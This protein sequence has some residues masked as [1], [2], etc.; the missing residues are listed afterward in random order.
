MYCA[1]AI[2]NVQVFLDTLL[3][4]ELKDTMMPHTFLRMGFYMIAGTVLAS[5]TWSTIEHS[6][7]TGDYIL[8]VILLPMMF[9]VVG[10]FFVDRWRPEYGPGDFH[11]TRLWKTPRDTTRSGLWLRVGFKT[12]VDGQHL[13]ANKIVFSQVNPDAFTGIIPFVPDSRDR[14]R[15]LF[16]FHPPE[17]GDIVIFLHPRDTSRVVVKRVIGLPGDMIEMEVGRVIRNGERL[18]EP[19]VVPRD[20]RTL[21]PVVAPAG[22][23]YVL[24]DNRLVSSDS[25]DWGFVPEELII[26][27]AWVRYWPSER[28][29]VLDGLR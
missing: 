6:A 14:G 20:G 11:P 18:E 7:V 8:S 12:L 1:G 21:E 23:Y 28:V 10:Q 16:T 17:R 27:R 2:L 4:V 29:G 3:P 22:S 15:S 25:R 9:F 13:I 26:G 19:Y 5:V 24:G